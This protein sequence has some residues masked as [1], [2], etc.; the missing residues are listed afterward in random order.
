MAQQIMKNNPIL[1]KEF[2]EDKNFD[3]DRHQPLIIRSKYDPYQQKIEYKAEEDSSE[4]YLT[5]DSN[6]EDLL[7]AQD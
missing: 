6:D 3:A 4:M 2:V 5:N 7:C 1:K